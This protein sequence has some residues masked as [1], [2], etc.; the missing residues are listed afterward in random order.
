MWQISV[1]LAVGI[2]I[3]TIGYH[4]ERKFEKFSSIAWLRSVVIAIAFSAVTLLPLPDWLY[5]AG[6]VVMAER[7]TCE[8]Y[9]TY[10]KADYRPH[11][12]CKI[13]GC[14]VLRVHGHYYRPRNKATRLER[15]L[16]RI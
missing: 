1:G 6:F 2:F 8:F 10:I 14:N 16:T 15:V 12:I 9:K 13:C 7:L 5:V 4:R 11:V 3:A